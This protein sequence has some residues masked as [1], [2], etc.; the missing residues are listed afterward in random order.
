M[1]NISLICTHHS[2]I[3]KCNS[4]EL[5]NII[6][7]IN[8]NI[9]FEELPNS[10]FDK[11]YNENILGLEELLE[12]VLEIKCIKKYLQTHNIKNIP[13]DIMTNS[14]FSKEINFVFDF[15]KKYDIYNEIEIEQ[16]KI[17]KIEGFAYLNSAKHSELLHKKKD[18][19]RK[20]LDLEG[21][22][23]KS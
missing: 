3:G 10:L 17:M 7:S 11:V 23:K 4:D 12:E 8:P 1:Q 14:I 9:I 18:I 15:F 16:K 5:Y 2:E 22:H 13:V 19:E 20:L 21:I 6:D